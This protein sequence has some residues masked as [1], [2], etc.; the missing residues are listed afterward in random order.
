MVRF[1][2]MTVNPD[3]RRLQGLEGAVDILKENGV[4]VSEAKNLALLAL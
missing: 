1:L 3:A 4:I 2:I